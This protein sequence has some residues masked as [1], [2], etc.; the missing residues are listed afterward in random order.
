MVDSREA[1]QCCGVSA[2]AGLSAPATAWNSMKDWYLSNMSPATSAL[3]FSLAGHLGLL[4]PSESKPL[5]VLETHCADA[6]MASIILP[7]PYV[8]SYTACDFSEAMVGEATALL[9]GNATVLVADSTELP[10]EA[11]SFDRYLSNLGCCCVSDFPRKLQEAR[12]VLVSGGMAAMSMRIQDYPGDNSM[13]LIQSSLSPFGYPPMPDREGLRMGK[14]L[15][16]LRARMKEAGFEEPRAAWRSW[17]TIP[18][19]DADDYVAWA[20]D[21]PPVKKFI[22]SLTPDKQAEAKVSLKQAA[23]IPAKDGA[24]QMAV[25]AVVAVAA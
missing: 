5:R 21:Q 10:F 19:K 18:I 24:I 9:G 12:R 4:S 2:P 17:I 1:G 8:K 20:L 11:A 16:A 25:C 6:R 23:E 14:D 13:I 7:T 15:D 3:A 22:N